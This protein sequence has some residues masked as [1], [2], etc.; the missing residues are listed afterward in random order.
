MRHR[1]VGN[2][3]NALLVEGAYKSEAQPRNFVYLLGS[4]VNCWKQALTLKFPI[5]GEDECKPDFSS[6][7]LCIVN[8][9]QT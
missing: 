7:T 5:A 2:G 4:P 3:D 1:N 6:T 8:T 9:D